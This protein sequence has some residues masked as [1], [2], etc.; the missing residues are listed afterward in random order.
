MKNL[1]LVQ[2]ADAFGLNKFLPLAIGYQWVYAK[3]DSWQLCD[4]LIEKLPVDRY[5]ESMVSPNMI[6]MSSYVWNWKYN[7]LLA[8]S[9][10]QKWPD[11]IIVVGGPQVPKNDPEFFKKY[12]MFDIAV[13]GE[14]EQAFKEILL[15]DSNFDG[16]PHVQTVGYFPEVA[17]RKKT[18][19][20]I[21]S[22]ILEGFY[23]P[24]IAK[25]PKDTVWQVSLETLR[26]CP[27]HCTFCDIGDSYWNKLTLFDIDRVKKEIDWIGKNKISYVSV[28]DSNWGLL[29][30]DIELTQY[31]ID[32]K[33]K[34]GYP[35]WWDATWAKNNL[36]KNFYIAMLNKK[37]GAN[38]F[39]GVTFAMQ[40]FNDD[41]LK[42]SERFNLEDKKVKNYLEKY[43][44]EN[45]T[46]YSELIWPMPEETYSSL[47]NGIQKLIDL[48][49][50]D[51][52][53][54]HPLVITDNAKMG[55]KFYQATYKIKTKIVPLDTYYLS[56]KNYKESVVE[57]TEAVYST[58]TASWN[59]VLRG[60]L[61]SWISI[62]MYYYG[63]GHYLI[64][65]LKSQGYKE[66]DVFEDL[67]IWIEKNTDTILYQ[68]YQATKQHIDQTYNNMS[69]WGRCVLGDDD[70]LWEYKGAS[71]I[72][73][74]NNRLSLG[75]E[76]TRFLSETYTDINA[77]KVVS[78]NLALCK[79]NDV[80]Y[81]ITISTDSNITKLMLG[82]EATELL[83]DHSSQ[84]PVDSYAF[85]LTAYHWQRKLGYWRCSFKKLM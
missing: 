24:I 58:R 39:K 70:I 57:T 6:A 34:T 13:H 59:D 9:V 35:E 83:V 29:D 69:P 36:E 48:G 8:A 31:V 14:G 51:F 38:L 26:G 71:S 67:L 52:L 66:T 78:L 4:V 85:F 76:L 61:F 1:Y 5:V 54:I 23:D 20:D 2:V 41:T 82:F 19:T 56:W 65:Y 32:T 79:Y 40:S 60:H 47:K 50:D 22:P 11:C 49:Q 84:H 72:V 18:V 37:S 73:F 64:K 68:E 62:T 44:Q 30:R 3:N 15:R 63:W 25:Y 16:I 17:Q 7:Q 21:P 43:K 74:H 10:K 53:M 12:P 46:T 81:P 80:E 33:L 28:C 27:Y 75:N 42:A 45:I 55:N 77:E